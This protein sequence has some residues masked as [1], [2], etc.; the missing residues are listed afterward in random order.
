[1]AISFAAYDSEREYF[2]PLIERFNQAN[3]AI[4]VSFVSLDALT[5][6]ADGE[7]YDS[8]KMMRRI[9]VGADTAAYVNPQPADIARGYLHDLKPLI[10]AD[11]AFDAGD[12]YP[13]ALERFSYN[14]G[15]YLA[16]RFLRIGL[17]AYNRDLWAKQGLPPPDPNWTRQD[18]LA[19]AQQLAEKR[20]DEIVVYGTLAASAQELLSYELESTGIDLFGKPPEQVRLDQPKVAAA[21]ERVVALARAGVVYT[22]APPV[23][24]VRTDDYQGLIFDGRAGMWPPYLVYWG[25]RSGDPPFPV[26]TAAAPVS[27]SSEYGGVE[28]YIM[29]AGTQHPEAAWRWLSFLSKQPPP[30]AQYQWRR[31]ADAGQIPAR[32]SIAA[33]VGYWQALDQEARAAVEAMLAR[34]VSAP[35]KTY[36]SSIGIPLSQAIDSVLYA[37][38]K[39]EQAL[40]DAQA[41]LEQQ[42]AQ[43]RHTPTPSVQEPIVVATP[44]AIQAHPD[45]TKITFGIASGLDTDTPR[46]IAETFNQEHPEILVDVLT[47]NAE[48]IEALAANSDCFHWLDPPRPQERSAL[49]D[50][51]PLL[52]ADASF[53]RDDYPPALLAPFQ[54]D[55]RLY[56]LPSSFSARMLVYNKV[57]FDAANLPYPA[58]GWTPDT[59]IATARK[60]TGGSGDNRRYGYAA[61]FGNTSEIRFFLN[62]YGALPLRGSGDS[63]QPSFS[64]P[65]VVQALRAYLDL[66]RSASPHQ[67]LQG[68]RQ[69]SAPEGQQIIGQGRVAM[70]FDYGVDVAMQR[71]QQSPELEIAVAPPPL[72]QRPLA[73][74]DMHVGGFYIAARTQAA[75]ACWAWLKALSEDS[76][77]LPGAF[78]A[79]IGV[80][81]SQRFQAQAAP[82]AAVVYQCYRAALF[83]RP[84]AVSET[85]LNRSPIDF[86]WFYRAIDRAL[87]GEDLE[88]ELAD[89]QALTEQFLIC[90]RGGTQAGTCAHQVDPQYDGRKSAE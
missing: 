35:P 51:Q 22:S 53:S 26:G 77:G 88:R 2:G 3:S 29:S 25:S 89:A 19:A 1:V 56:G 16:P 4:Q 75:Q 28:G 57:A 52:D 39:P 47:S 9:V 31:P 82:G 83:R 54:Q 58:A 86:Y 73:P 81:E 72:G 66:L 43:A 68:Y 14:G 76:V 69:Q 24:Q 36:A 12:F 30:S 7:P 21:L 50:L 48:T 84:D 64:D 33:Q 62:A 18:M 10:D 90:V 65:E 15:V 20:G 37:G 59:L 85:D 80:A 32:K 44:Q 74:D 87:Q 49:L 55:G 17:L 23:G 40:R 79:R 70:W 27:P 8:D 11:A 67:Q 34:P 60:L 41:Q 63:Q 42:L 38:Q 13:G 46:R 5:Q 71:Q 6:L 45:A 61:L 78:P